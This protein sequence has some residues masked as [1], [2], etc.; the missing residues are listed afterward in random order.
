MGDSKKF[1]KILKDSTM[2]KN[3]Q[4]EYIT[5]TRLENISF[6]KTS[7]FKDITIQR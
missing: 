5:I 2:A 6:K 7:I 4:K 3:I 1:I